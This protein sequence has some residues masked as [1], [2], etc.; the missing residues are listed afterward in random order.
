[1]TLLHAKL[2]QCLSLAVHKF[3]AAGEECCEQSYGLVILKQHCLIVGGRSATH[4]E[5]LRL[6]ELLHIMLCI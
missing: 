5:K 3:C 4:S 6:V 2:P 1:M